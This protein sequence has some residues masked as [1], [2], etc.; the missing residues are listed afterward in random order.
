MQTPLVIGCDPEV[1]LQSPSGEFISSIGK[2]GGSKDFP[3]PIDEDG[4][5]VQEDNVA[6]EFNT[7]PCASAGE[8]I[9]HIRKNLAFLEEL[10]G[11]MNLKISVVPSA[12]FSA[13][14]LSHPQ[15]KVF[16]CEPD[17]DAWRGGMVNPPP[18]AKNKALRSAGGH[19]HIQL[20]GTLDEVEVI[21]AMDVFVACV[22]LEY[23]TDQ[24]RRELYGKPGAFRYKPYGVE[25]RTPSN[26]WI[27]SDTLIEKVYQQTEKAVS[28]VASGKTIDQD[29]E[30]YVKAALMTGDNDAAQYLIT[31]YNVL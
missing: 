26:V 30:A 28:F 13:E 1:F 29:D 9:K 12:V 24:R 23:D 31:K 21:K 6:V 4:N 10:A 3:R 25:Y 5:A 7:P 16:G 8:F 14:E 22:L 18:R 19:I 17:Y 2:I 20:D 27:Q 15:A 11:S